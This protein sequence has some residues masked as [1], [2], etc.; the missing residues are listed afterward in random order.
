MNAVI[1]SPFSIIYD[2]YLIQFL[3]FGHFSDGG[4]PLA[5]G[6]REDA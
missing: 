6:E 3:R 2:Y 1:H 4:G 5:L